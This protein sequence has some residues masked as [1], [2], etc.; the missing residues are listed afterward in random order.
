MENFCEKSRA[1]CLEEGVSYSQ[2][3]QQDLMKFFTKITGKEDPKVRPVK[4]IIVSLCTV[5]ILFYHF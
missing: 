4:L 5:R 3:N 1:E 2:G